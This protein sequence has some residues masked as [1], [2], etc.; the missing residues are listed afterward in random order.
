MTTISRSSSPPSKPEQSSAGGEGLRVAPPEEGHFLLGPAESPL[1]VAPATAREFVLDPADAEHYVVD[2]MGSSHQDDGHTGPPKGGPYVPKGGPY[3]PTGFGPYE[4]ESLL[5]SGG[6]GDVYRAR[7]IRL[8]RT[9]A[10]KVLRPDLS[11]NRERRAQ[12]AT[13]A[14]SVSALTHPHIRTV[15]DIGSEGGLDFLVLEYLEGETLDRILARR[16]LSVGRALTYAFQIADA[17]DAAHRRGIVHGDVKPANIMI[18]TSGVK[19]LDFGLAKLAEPQH[20]PAD[21]T[22]TDHA[23]IPGTTP[24]LAPERLE[25]RMGDP[26]SDVFAL[27]VVVYEMIAGRRP[28][29]GSTRARIIASILEHEPVPLTSAHEAVSPALQHLVLRCLAKDP[30]QRWQNA[31]DLAAEIEWIA[32]DGAIVRAPSRARIRPRTIAW[33]AAGIVGVAGTLLG[34]YAWRAQPA[35]ATS[36]ASVR[37]IAE[38]PLGAAMAVSPGG[39]S[40]SPDGRHLVF[41]ASAGTGTRQLWLRSLDSFETR[42]LPGTDDAWN[43]FWAADSQSIAFTAGAQL[44]RIDLRTNRVQAIADVPSSVNGAWGPDGTILLSANTGPAR[45][46]TIPPTGGAPVDVVF[47]ASMRGAIISGPDFLPDGRHFIYHARTGMP[48]TTGIYVA[49]LDRGDNRFIAVSDSQADYAEPGFLIYLRNGSMLAQ[50]F[51]P[52]ELAVTGPAKTLP[53]AVSFVPG[54]DRGGFSISRGP[55]LAYRA[56]V[57]S[58]ELLWRDRVGRQIGSLGTGTYINPALSPDGTRVAVTRGDATAGTSDIWIIDTNGGMR[59]LTSGPVVEN[60]PVWSPDGT[61]IAFAAERNGAMHLFEKDVNA[62]A[63]D[64]DDPLVTTQPTKMPYDWSRDG[65]FLLYSSFEGRGMLGARFWA[66]TVA[67]GH[68]SGGRVASEP[69]ELASSSPGKE[70]G[71]AQISPDGRWMAYVSDVSG[72]PQVFVRP[73]PHGA[74]RW[75]ISTS[76]GFE[77]KWRADGRELFYLA[78]DQMMMAVD[79]DSGSTFSAG[80]PHPLFRTNLMG[81]YL[82]SPFPNGRVRNEYA[83]TPDGQRFLINQPVGGISAYAIRIVTDW[84]SLLQ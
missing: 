42:P 12:F 19:L 70:E 52:I 33:A 60:F 58:S 47:P 31:K 38:A 84:Q 51:D 73:F 53:E 34:A 24:Y 72:S 69:S 36:H 27:G 82:G 68:E 49:S 54:L 78:S 55:V 44:R 18:T 76:G 77:P 83:V 21:S 56:R 57:E 7:D 3:V 32:S 26:R 46:M 50:P 37:F 65:R 61:R 66:I 15:F 45:L 62:G 8:G 9:V 13:E 80:Q 2:L 41:I 48:D 74:G 25:G 79:V 11:R 5:G 20:D 16:P 23:A 30:D 71:Q 40:V 43:P 64:A 75:L 17:L 29:E 4:I 14:R 10:V 28:F 22:A 81:A 35:A 6:M 67:P 39:F 63:A 59:Q 1:Y